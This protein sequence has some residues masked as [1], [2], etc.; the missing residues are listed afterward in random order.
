MKR[1][2]WIVMTTVATLIAAY[3]AAVLLLPGFG[4]PLIIARRTT[5]PLA[6]WAH[7]GGGLV[8]LR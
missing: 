8:A 5:M 7:L 6:V 4:P 1:A 2:L 3:A